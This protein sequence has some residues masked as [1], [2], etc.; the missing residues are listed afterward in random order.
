MT[1]KINIKIRE[2]FYICAEI[3]LSIGITLF[4]YK[5]TLNPYA[6]NL[7]QEEYNCEQ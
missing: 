2:T 6:N 5:M 3:L 7:S 4:I 1:N